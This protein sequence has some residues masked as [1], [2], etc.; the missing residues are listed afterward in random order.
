M[1][2]TG[3]N[4]NELVL[5]MGE[6]TKAVLRKG[7]AKGAERM[8]HWVKLNTP[9]EGFL[10]AIAFIDQ[11]GRYTHIKPPPGHLRDSINEKALRVYYDA[12]GLL[13]YETG[14]QTDVPYGPFVEEGTGLWGPQHREYVIRP[15][16][17]D[18]WLSWITQHGFVRRDGKFVP[19]GTRV[20]AK[21]VRHPGSP[22]NHM[23]KIGALMVEREFGEFM[24][25][26]IDEWKVECDRL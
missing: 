20:F 11:Q 15:K 9:V 25:P 5:A 21:E 24:G 8:V 10:K 17:P 4:L 13:V 23:F 1:G 2:Y 3:G 14:A 6:P 16:R 18:G 26:I 12:Q 22:G 19:P 7:A